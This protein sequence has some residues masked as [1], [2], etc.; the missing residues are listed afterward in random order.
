LAAGA[1]GSV[2]PL[3]AACDE[4]VAG[5]LART[6][7]TV[8]LIGSGRHT[9][10][11]TS[12]DTGSLAGFGTDPE[13]GSTTPG[14]ETTGSGTTGSGTTERES[15]GT[16]LQLDPPARLPL[17]LAIG[18]WLLERA[19]CRADLVLQEVA[20]ESSAEDCRRLGVQLA[21]DTGPD[22]VWLALG[23]GSNRRGPR[24]PGHED[25]R[26]AD[27]D[28]GVA[29]AFAAGDPAALLALDVALAAV[30]GAAGRG[31]WQALA[32]AVAAAPGWPSIDAAVLYDDAPFGVEYLVAAWQP[33]S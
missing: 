32:G 26:A 23:D 15:S 30:L 13:P 18:R 17:S 28:A 27:F 31:V 24:S 6:P 22:S 8:V 19:G 16:T 7:S 4:V 14:S 25:P 3:L 20:V 5:L 10:A 9:R 21:T 11:W 33:R 1:A 12:Q 2:A 29:R